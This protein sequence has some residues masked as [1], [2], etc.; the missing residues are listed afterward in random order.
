MEVIDLMQRQF[1]AAAHHDLMTRIASGEI[2][3]E[4]KQKISSTLARRSFL[5]NGL[6]GQICRFGWLRGP[7][8]AETRK[9]WPG[10]HSKKRSRNL[11]PN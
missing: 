1:I 5:S 6:P 7:D 11:L 8:H 10:R 4:A 3:T 9:T 2:D